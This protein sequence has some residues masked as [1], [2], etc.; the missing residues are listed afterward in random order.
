MGIVGII[1][2]TVGVTNLTGWTRIGA[3]VASAGL[4]GI[5][6]SLVAAHFYDVAARDFAK[7]FAAFTLARLA[8]VRDEA[9]ASRVLRRRH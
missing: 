2:V 6:A 5:A 7:S 9:P 1:E 4:L 3:S 8:Q